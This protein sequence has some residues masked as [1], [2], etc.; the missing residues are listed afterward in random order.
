MFPVA[1]GA[2]PLVALLLYV[3]GSSC[4]MSSTTSDAR[5]RLRSKLEPSAEAPEDLEALQRRTELMEDMHEP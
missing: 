3:S 2:V 5:D 4:P 1:R